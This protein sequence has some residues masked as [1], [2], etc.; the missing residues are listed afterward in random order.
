LDRRSAWKSFALDPLSRCIYHVN[1]EFDWDAANLKHI[2]K[3]GI[4]PEE[5]EE[6]VLIEPLETDLQERQ[7]EQ[8]VVCFGRTKSG[9]LLTVLY[10]ER[11]GKVRVVTAYPMTKRQ[12]QSYFEGK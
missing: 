11:R 12:Q 8:R 5:T 1:A 6:A 3:H 10:T 9:R 7:S 2:A 4:S